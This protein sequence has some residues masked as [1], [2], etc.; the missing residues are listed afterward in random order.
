MPSHQSLEHLMRGK[1]RDRRSPHIQGW[2]VMPSH[3]CEQNYSIFSINVKDTFAF[4]GL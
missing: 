4:L 1:G 3:K 2:V